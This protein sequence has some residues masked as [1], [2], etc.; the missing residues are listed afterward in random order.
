MLQSPLYAAP[1]RQEL[2]SRVRPARSCF[3]QIEGAVIRIRRIVIRHRY[4]TITTPNLNF[5]NVGRSLRNGPY[6]DKSLYL[7]IAA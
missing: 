5:A 7:P 4:A 3:H 2:A 6:W 1:K